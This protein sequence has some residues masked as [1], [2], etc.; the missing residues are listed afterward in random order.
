MKVKTMLV[1]YVVFSVSLMVGLL[2]CTFTSTSSG[3]KK[4]LVKHKSIN[5]FITVKLVKQN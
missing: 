4:N 2:D 1:V 5:L 3:G